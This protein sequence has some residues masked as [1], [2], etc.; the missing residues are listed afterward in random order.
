MLLPYTCP[1]KNLKEKPFKNG[2]KTQIFTYLTS[3]ILGYYS[4]LGIFVPDKTNI[5]KF[6]FLCLFS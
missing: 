3:N 4:Q 1:A 2:R 5:I 6:Q